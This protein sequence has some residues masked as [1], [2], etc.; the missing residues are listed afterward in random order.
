MRLRESGVIAFEG[1]GEDPR[2][3]V[4]AGGMAGASRRAVVMGAL[5]RR[6]R[7]MAMLPAFVAPLMDELGLLMIVTAGAGDGKTGAGGMARAEQRGGGYDQDFAQ[8]AK[9]RASTTSDP[10]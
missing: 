7:M 8:C 5:M 9:H 1:F 10:V 3:A 4:R 6:R 2:I